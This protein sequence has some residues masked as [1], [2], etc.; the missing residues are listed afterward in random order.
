MAQRLKEFYEQA[1]GDLQDSQ[2]ELEA[3]ARQVEGLR[4]ECDVA[5]ELQEAQVAGLAELDG[6]TRRLKW[7]EEK[8]TVTCQSTV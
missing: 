1:L 8:E 5:K 6:D 3:S 7:S 2:Q 4:N